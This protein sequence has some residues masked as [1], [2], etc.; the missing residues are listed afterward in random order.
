MEVDFIEATLHDR[1][2]GDQLI[3]NAEGVVIG[4][5]LKCAEDHYVLIAPGTESELMPVMLTQKPEQSSWY[6]TR[7]SESVE[8]LRSS[9]AV[10][11]HA[12]TEQRT[13]EELWPLGLDGFENRLINTLSG[14]QL[15]RSLFARVLLQDQQVILLDEPFNA[16]D[17]KTIID[18][19]LV[20]KEWQSKNRTVIMVTHDL[21]YVKDNC[22][23][24]ML[25][26]KECIDFGL[27]KTVLTK[28][29]LDNAKKVSE[30]FN[31]NSAWCIK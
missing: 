22:P 26:A 11:L 23:S 28:E 9:G 6:S 8:G 25:L 3:Y 29:N 10:V 16:I 19:T 7:S 30:A 20:I 21:E 12:H 17:P 27:T 14:G 13:F 15:Q 4:N 18:L 5:R 31:E 2:A 1:A 24:S